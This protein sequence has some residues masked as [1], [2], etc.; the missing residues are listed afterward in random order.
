MPLGNRISPQFQLV[1]GQ[2]RGAVGSSSRRGGCVRAFNRLAA[3]K[4]YSVPSERL[5]V[6]GHRSGSLTV[7]NTLTL[8]AFAFPMTNATT[9][10]YQRSLAQHLGA[11]AK[12]Q[13]IFSQEDENGVVHVYSV[14]DEFDDKVY[15][16]LL[17]RERL[18][19]DDFPD[20]KL[21]FHLRASQG[22]RPFLAVPFDARPVFLR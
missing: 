17:K 7:A 14:V 9:V 3:I 10:P 13:A 19:E 1:T 21:E 20:A 15:K 16:L 8:K 18:V 5:A 4:C 12:V 2:G 22:R 6:V 11:V